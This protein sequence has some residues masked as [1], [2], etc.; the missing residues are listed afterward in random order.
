M[1]EGRMIESDKIKCGIK[2]LYNGELLYN[3]LM[4]VYNNINVC[5]LT[6]ETL[7]PKNIVISYLKANGLK[8][9][10]NIIKK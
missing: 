3:I 9:T 2:V 8:F 4:D 10:E 6:V 7:N 1:Y 5:G